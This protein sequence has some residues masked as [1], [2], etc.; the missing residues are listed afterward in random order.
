MKKKLLILHSY[1]SLYYPD[2]KPVTGTKTYRV[3]TKSTLIVLFFYW[4]LIYLKN[5]FSE[6]HTISFNWKDPVK[7]K[8]SNSRQ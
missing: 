3:L 7:L 2:S 8:N 6:L 4:R 1:F 5:W